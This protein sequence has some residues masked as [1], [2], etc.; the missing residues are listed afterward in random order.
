MVG[1]WLETDFIDT[2]YNLALEQ[3]ILYLQPHNEFSATVRFWTNPKAVILGR[4]QQIE[5]EIN[6]AYCSEN[7]IITG[8]RI[9]G[10]GTVFLDSGTLNISIFL[11]RRLLFPRARHTRSISKYFS[12]RIVECL[13][14]ELGINKFVIYQDTSILFNQKK[15]SGSAGYFRSSWFLHHLTLLLQTN[16]SH[17]DQ[18]LLAGKEQYSSK[19]PS[20]FFPTANLPPLSKTKLIKRFIKQLEEEFSHAFNKYPIT[21]SEKNLARRL[22]NK[23]YS[24]SSWIWDKKRGL[25]EQEF[26]SS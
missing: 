3:A 17:L 22:T 25:I 6:I 1:R 19:R 21:E 10:G 8:R 5:E 14:A 20:S 4:S 26:S 16:L 13:E 7:N 15:I 12:E 2:H 24:Q 23:M 11:P 9:S 18:A